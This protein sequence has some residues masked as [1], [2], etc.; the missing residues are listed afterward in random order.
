MVWTAEASLPSPRTNGDGDPL[1]VGSWTKLE[2]AGAHFLCPLVTR[3]LQCAKELAW[4]F[5]QRRGEQN[6]NTGVS[7]S[8]HAP[9]NTRPCFPSIDSQSWGVGDGGD[10]KNMPHADDTTGFLETTQMV[11]RLSSHSHPPPS[12]LIACW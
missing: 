10:V 2:R 12:L 11:V 7:F 5:P 6:H 9:V 3:M 4:P 1:C 8:L